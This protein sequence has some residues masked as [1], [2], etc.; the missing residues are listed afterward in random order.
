MYSFW[1]LDN[2][3]IPLASY[4]WLLRGLICLEAKNC[5]T[6]L[7]SLL[8]PSRS[9]LSKANLTSSARDGGLLGLSFHSFNSFNCCSSVSIKIS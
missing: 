7:P 6:A 3:N 5:L 8:L 2:S 9:S 4:S 1:S